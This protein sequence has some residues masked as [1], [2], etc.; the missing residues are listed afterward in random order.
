VVDELKLIHRHAATN[1]ESGKHA[2]QLI[3]DKLKALELRSV[4]GQLITNGASSFFAPQN[5]A[6][7]TRRK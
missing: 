2:A 1:S 3:L 4:S 5:G 7:K 6:K